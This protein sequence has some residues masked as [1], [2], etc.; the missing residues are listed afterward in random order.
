M[1]RGLVTGGCLIVAAV[2]LWGSFVV[3]A[4]TPTGALLVNL[5]TE[6]VGIVMTVAV[7]EWFVE[8]R[9]LHNRGR[10]IAWDSFH[11]VQHAVWVWQGGP[12]EMDADELRGLL[13]AVADD[14]PVPDFTEEL[15]L[16]IGSRSRRLLDNDPAA[17]EAIP[18]LMSGLEHLARLISLRDGGASKPPRSIAD[19]LDE[20]TWSLARALG[21]PTERHLPSLI[22]YR[23]PSLEM[24]ERRH[25]GGGSAVGA[26]EARGLGAA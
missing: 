1:L 9:R 2:V 12:R 5:G 22:W 25:Y 13:D 6:I 4:G 3:G 15:L 18:G 10:Q 23:D 7:V 21:R 8:R 16:N 20:A 14:D 26:R 19:I 17:I 11:T 24:Q